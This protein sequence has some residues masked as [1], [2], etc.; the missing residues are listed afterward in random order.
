MGNISKKKLG[1]WHNLNQKKIKKLRGKNLL[2][3]IEKS[4]FLKNINKKKVWVTAYDEVANA[5]EDL[6]VLA[7]FLAEGEV[8]ESEVKAQYKI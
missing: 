7:D 1:I 5:V 2:T 4:M 6:I 8:E 3:K